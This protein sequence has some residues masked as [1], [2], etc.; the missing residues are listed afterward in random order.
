MRAIDEL[1]GEHKAVLLALSLLEEMAQAVATGSAAARSDLSELL[2]FFKGF[3]DRCH[4]AKEEEVLFPELERL[5]LARSEGPLAALLAEHEVGRGHVRALASALQRLQGG[6][7]T[8]AVRIVQHA[9]ACGDTL[10]AHIDNED[11]GLFVTAGRLIPDELD[12]GLTERFGLIE[13]ERIGEGQ[14]EAYHALLRRLKAA[15]PPSVPELAHQPAPW[16]G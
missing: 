6:D 1:K 10:R 2:G 8:A 3:V 11:N 12:A 4:H 9:R 13:R 5:G 7:D 15:Y 16:H 14:H